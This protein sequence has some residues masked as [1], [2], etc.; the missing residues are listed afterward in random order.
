M[1]ELPVTSGALVRN[2]STSRQHRRLHWLRYF[3]VRYVAHRLHAMVCP[4][5]F[6][7]FLGAWTRNTP[8]A[9]RL[10]QCFGGC[11]KANAFRCAERKQSRKKLQRSLSH[12]ADIGRPH[13]ADGAYSCLGFSSNSMTFL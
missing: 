13:H 7:R 6:P 8:S 4:S 10:R 5:V 3:A 12:A 1:Q 11:Y 2:N 9:T